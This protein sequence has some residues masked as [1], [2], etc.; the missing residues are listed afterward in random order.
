[1][2]RA[3]GVET[4]ANRKFTFEKKKKKKNNY[5][6]SDRGGGVDLQPGEGVFTPLGGCTNITAARNLQYCS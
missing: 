4:R 3:G 1:L 5:T 6:Q 2:G